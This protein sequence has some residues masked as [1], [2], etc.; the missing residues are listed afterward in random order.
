MTQDQYAQAHEEAIQVLR[1][2]ASGMLVL[3]DLKDR[4]AA[5]DAPYPNPSQ[6]TGLVDPA[7]GLSF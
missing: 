7:T 1:E 2:Y 6:H 4:I 3:S 5:I